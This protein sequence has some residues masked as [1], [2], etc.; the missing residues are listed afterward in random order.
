MVAGRLKRL[1][2]LFGPCAGGR[3]RPVLGIGEARRYT[4]PCSALS[5]IALVLERGKLGTVRALAPS[6]PA[7]G[8]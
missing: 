5:S 4:C 7:L 2:A 1:S 8:A 3:R 6:G